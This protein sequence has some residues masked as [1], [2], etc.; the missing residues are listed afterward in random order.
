M[1]STAPAAN[2]DAY[3]HVFLGRGHDAATRR[4]STAHPRGV[5]YYR[6]RLAGFRALS[7]LTIEVVPEARA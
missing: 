3:S 1:E 5:D 4:T 7:H 2:R 6:T